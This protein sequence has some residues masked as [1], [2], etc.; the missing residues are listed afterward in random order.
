MSELFQSAEAGTHQILIEHRSLLAAAA[1]LEAAAEHLPSQGPVQLEHRAS[2]AGML[3][4]FVTKLASH[5][6]AEVQTS[7]FDAQ[8][9]VMA[10]QLRE[11]DEEH[12]TLL[13]AFNAAQRMA[14]TEGT[15]APALRQLI[16]DTVMAFRDHEA[17]E[18][19]LF[20]EDD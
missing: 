10:A 20:G 5:F 6:D 13:A 15:R 8:D 11:L 12:R 14:R 16:V 4:E 18:D 7:S 9:S 19:A 2:L 1:S 3:D 17:K